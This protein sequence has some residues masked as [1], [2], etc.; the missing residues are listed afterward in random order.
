LTVPSAFYEQVATPVTQ[1]V[2]VLVA[3]E[4]KYPD[5]QVVVYQIPAHTYALALPAVHK[6]H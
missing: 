2:H 1:V 4:K 6:V 5:E 3:V